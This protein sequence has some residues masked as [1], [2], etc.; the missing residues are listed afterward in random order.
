MATV[1]M[2]TEAVKLLTA[3]Y[4]A[5]LEQLNHQL[6]RTQAELAQIERTYASELRSTAATP[7]APNTLRNK[8]AGAVKTKAPSTAR[9][10]KSV[11][12]K[13]SGEGSSDKSAKTAGAKT[14]IAK[15][16]SSET[17][18]AKTRAA[19]TS[20]A[21]ATGAGRRGTKTAD[22]NSLKPGVDQ[23]VPVTESS[24]AKRKGRPA[25]N[26]GSIPH[27]INTAG[28]RTVR[29]SKSSDHPKSSGASP[30]R[31]SHK[32]SEWDQIMI[33]SLEK[34]GAPLRKAD[35]DEAFKR[36]PLA[37]QSKMSAEDVYIKVARVIHKLANVRKML[38]KVNVEGKGYAYALPA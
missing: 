37:K 8:A 7:I 3:S 24:T 13:A 35:L 38:K 23:A 31:K 1:K 22:Q 9:K 16:S 19:K 30:K 14:S 29:R 11:K 21:K 18:A 4:K 10:A 27:S 17:R 5:Q 6:Q 34:A 33:R 25:K 28:T 12:V 26:S 36:H 15:A 32:L 2:S 20:N